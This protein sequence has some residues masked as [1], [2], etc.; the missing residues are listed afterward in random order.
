M[1]DLAEIKERL[2]Q[3]PPGLALDIDDTLSQ[4]WAYWGQEMLRCFGNPE[5]LTWE[6][7]RAK[8]RRCE[9]VPY[10]QTEEAQTWMA[11]SRR[12]GAYYEQLERMHGSH[13]NV[14]RI[15]E[16]L[17]I[18]LY[19]T[20]RSIEMLD[21]T[22]TWLAKH[23]YP[24]V[25]VISRPLDVP[26]EDTYRWKS[27]VL[28]ELYPHITGIVDD[29]ANLPSHLPVDYQGTV[30]IIGK[31]TNERDDVRLHHC[32]TWEDVYQVVHANHGSQKD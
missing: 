26:Y 10:W 28:T 2:K 22:R 5:N 25:E 13:E 1:Y 9:N 16:H 3:A 7:I 11:E 29:D 18:H 14:Y 30:Y 24:D 12:G 4:T 6:E 32:P 27:S 20:A 8:Y 31:E 15:Q 19:L 23:G 17:P 21:T